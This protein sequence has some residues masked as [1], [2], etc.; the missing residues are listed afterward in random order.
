MQGR[1]GARKLRAR[2]PRRYR[3]N[4]LVPGGRPVNREPWKGWMDDEQRDNYM[5]VSISAT[6]LE[7]VLTITVLLLLFWAL[8]GE[9]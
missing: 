3:V 6:W 2:V 7:L 5:S 9:S 4:F 8:G 1:D